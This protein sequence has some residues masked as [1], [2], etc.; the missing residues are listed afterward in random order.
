MRSPSSNKK[1]TVIKKDKS[2]DFIRIFFDIFLGG[3][4]GDSQQGEPSQPG[5][6]FE[7]HHCLM[8]LPAA[9]SPASLF[10]GK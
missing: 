2:V 8:V 9:S 3:D 7:K 1:Y 4:R 10:L 5:K 6:G